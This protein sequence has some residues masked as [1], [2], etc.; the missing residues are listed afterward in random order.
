M[1][2][3]AAPFAPGSALA[4]RLSVVP[5]ASRWLLPVMAVA[6]RGREGT[7]IEPRARLLMLLRIAAVDRSPYWRRQLEAAAGAVGV[8]A[9]EV[10]LAWSDEWEAAPFGDRDRAAIL[11]GDRVARRMARRDAAAY[12]AVREVFT[13]AELVELTMV[14]SLASMADRVTNALRIA[15]EP[16]TGLSPATTPVPDADLASWSR[17]A[18]DDAGATDA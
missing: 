11:W 1:T 6:F 4:D 18:F 12:R 15:P 17:R 2:R 16:P 5:R 9:D 13:E 10:E 14:A 3:S 7:T 8:T